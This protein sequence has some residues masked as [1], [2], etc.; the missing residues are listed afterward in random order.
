MFFLNSLIMIL[1]SLMAVLTIAVLKA[2]FSKRGTKQVQC[3][4]DDVH[5]ESLPLESLGFPYQS[6]PWL[7]R[8]GRCMQRWFHWFG[9]FSENVD[10][11][12]I[13]TLV[14]LPTCVFYGLKIGMARMIMDVSVDVRESLYGRV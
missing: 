11:S 3:V 5:V 6:L 13:I 9:R 12:L 14:T 10:G 7:E 8:Q 2:N 1:S 4:D